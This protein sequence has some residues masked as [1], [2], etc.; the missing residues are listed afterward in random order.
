MGP[1]DGSSGILASTTVPLQTDLTI[2]IAALV[3]VAMTA[4]TAVLVYLAFGPHNRRLEDA[5]A[6]SES[7]QA[8]VDE[9]DPKAVE[10]PTDG[11]ER[12]A[13][14]DDD[15]GLETE[16]SPGPGDGSPDSLEEG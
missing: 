14:A 6:R 4:F 16:T 3:I 12:E 9:S 7:S 8:T 13:D 5:G 11:S 1:I 15:V 10:S 2:G